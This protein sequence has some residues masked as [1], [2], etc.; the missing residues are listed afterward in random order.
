MT[1]ARSNLETVE[2]MVAAYNA[3][4]RAGSTAE[5]AAA[6]T[7]Q[8]FDEFY[9]PEVRWVEAPTPFFPSGRSG[10]RAELEAAAREV[11]TLLSE[12]RYTLVDAFAVDDRV[13]AEYSWEATYREDDRRLRI[14]LVTLYRMRDDAFTEVHEY[15]CA[16][17]PSPD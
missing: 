12:R 5:E 13:A 17:A 2:R 3:A 14:R 16:E 11:S 7:L 10:G 1:E 6:R 8:V 4:A 9:S 15:P